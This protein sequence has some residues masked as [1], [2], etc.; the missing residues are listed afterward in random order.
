MADHVVLVAPATLLHVVP[1]LVEVCH[2]T[3]GA[4]EPDAAALN[5]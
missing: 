5:E 4:G 2:W 1:P 3:D